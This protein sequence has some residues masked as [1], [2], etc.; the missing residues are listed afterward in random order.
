METVQIL[1]SSKV[2]TNEAQLDPKAVQAAALTQE[3]RENFVRSP[4]EIMRNYANARDCRSIG[5]GN[6]EAGGVTSLSPIAHFVHLHNGDELKAKI[7][8][9]NA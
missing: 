2:L 1:P 5:A 9:S 7:L 4:L 8:W 6:A 3:R